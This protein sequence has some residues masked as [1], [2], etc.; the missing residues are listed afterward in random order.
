MKITGYEKPLIRYTKSE[1]VQIAKNY[2]VYYTSEVGGGKISGYEKL[3]KDELINLIS[4]DRDYISAEKKYTQKEEK[5]KKEKKKVD[6]QKV[7]DVSKK[8]EIDLDEEEK[9]KTRLELLKEKTSGILDPENMMIEIIDILKETDIIP[10]VGKYYT[11]I[12][13]AKTPNIVYDQHP[14]IA[15]LSIQ[16]WGFT[17]LN[18][19]WGKQRNYT[20]EEV[21]GY[22]HIVNS[23]ELEY[24]KTLKYAKFISK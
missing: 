6:T 1:L 23:D 19:H 9:P 12:Y 3:S 10:E 5:V 7:T 17:G 15:T 2:T 16:N 24:L 20:W 21:A 14:L 4:K 8:K 13:N 18:F 22:L 11:F